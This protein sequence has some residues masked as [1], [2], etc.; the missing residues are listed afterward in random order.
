M[1][2][3]SYVS[4]PEG[5][6]IWWV[7]VPLSPQLFFGRPIIWESRLA[8]VSTAWRWLFVCPQPRDD[9]EDRRG[10]YCAYEMVSNSSS[11]PRIHKQLEWFPNLYSKCLNEIWAVPNDSWVSEGF[12][13]HRVE[14]LKIILQVY[15]DI[16]YYN[17]YIYYIIIY[18]QL[19]HHDLG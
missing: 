4:L 14:Y 9:N 12:L 8:R 1:I 11:K 17:V 5:N 10:V 2:F 18:N 13:V 19:D 7:D 15:K 6:A 16:M 3:H